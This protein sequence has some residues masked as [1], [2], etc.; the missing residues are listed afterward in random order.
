MAQI[1]RFAAIRRIF[2]RGLRDRA[3]AMAIM[4]ALMLPIFVAA[5]G[6]VIDAGYYRYRV[7]VLQSASDSAALAAA[8]DGVAGLSTAVQMWSAADTE[9]VRNGFMDG[10]FGWNPPGTTSTARGSLVVNSPPS[11]SA[12]FH[13]QL[14]Y[15]EVVLT[16]NRP[17]IFAQV[18]M[19]NSLQSLV[20][21]SVVKATSSGGSA[22]MSNGTGSGCIMAID[23]GSAQTFRMQNQGSAVNPGCEVVVNSTNGGAVFLNGQ[24]QQHIVMGSLLSY[25]GGV[26]YNNG[27]GYVDFG[28]PPAGV[29]SNPNHLS[30]AVPDPYAASVVPTTIP[31]AAAGPCIDIGGQPLNWNGGTVNLPAGHYCKGFAINGGTVNLSPGITY[32]DQQFQIQNG[33]TVNGLNGSTLVIGNG[34]TFQMSGGHLNLKAPTSGITAGLALT[35]YS[36]SG[37]NGSTVFINNNS[38]I[39]FTGAIYFPRRLFYLQQTGALS[40]FG[41]TGGCGHIIAWQVD[42]E[43]G[44]SI[45]D[46]CSGIG[47][48]PFGTQSASWASSY[49][50]PGATATSGTTTV[51]IVE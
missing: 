17:R 31:A 20:A 25:V 2:E 48:I 51:S 21:H 43:N 30:K 23:P 1:G 37:A 46:N 29:T 4:V 40:A 8:R 12:A 15:V 32:V 5:S 26:N 11:I 9:A 28:A 50:P 44:M 7:R 34:Y 41:G 10:N 38:T 49:V 33:A 39:Q 3:G 14:G 45:G 19:G 36:D 35:E 18:W 16:E 22:T 47:V 6:L 13:G 42:V 27:A 24:A